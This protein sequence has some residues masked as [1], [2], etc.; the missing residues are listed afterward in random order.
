MEDNYDYLFKVL[1]I[2]E[3]SVGKTSVLLRHTD[4]IFNPSFQATIGVDFRLSTIQKHG[5][6]HKL[7]LWDTAGQDRYRRIVNS[8]Y[9]GASGVIIVYDITSR[10]S[11]NQ[12]EFWLSQIPVPSCVK[13]L[14]ANKNDLEKERKVTR[15]EGFELA[16]KLGMEFI[17]TSAK[18]N[19][20]VD[21][22]FDRLLENMI[23]DKIR[24]NSN[25]GQVL[26]GRNQKVVEAKI[27]CY[28]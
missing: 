26:A 23:K 4:Q 15:N 27:C 1:L 10:D 25:T 22:V 9:R 19:K 11:F 6:V 3:S 21:E 12:V 17:E 2:G 18:E 28:I 8:Y 16:E 14:V 7:Q 20:N 13:V 5:K 24:G